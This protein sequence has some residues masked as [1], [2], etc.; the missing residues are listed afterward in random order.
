MNDDRKFQWNSFIFC[1]PIILLTQA[2]P[3][4]PVVLMSV[5]FSAT[6]SLLIFGYWDSSLFT[7]AV[8]RMKMNLCIYNS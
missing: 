7:V 6:K 4:H 3:S 1:V 2:L 5:T 8:A